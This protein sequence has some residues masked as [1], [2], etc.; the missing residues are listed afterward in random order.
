MQSQTFHIYL[1]ISLS[2]LG[3]DIKLA[4]ETKLKKLRCIYYTFLYNL[5]LLFAFPFNRQLDLL[6]INLFCTPLNLP[7][8]L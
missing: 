4:S 2:L 1:C 5:Y 6:L 3:K 7:F 8:N